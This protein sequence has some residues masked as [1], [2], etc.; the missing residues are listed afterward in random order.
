MQKSCRFSHDVAHMFSAI[1]K[2]LIFGCLNFAEI[3]LKVEESGFLIIVM[4]QSAAKG[5]L[6]VTNNRIH[7]FNKT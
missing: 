1:V 5:L 6:T 4:H 7:F 2:D 3:I